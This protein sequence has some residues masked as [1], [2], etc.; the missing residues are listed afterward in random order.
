MRHD[1]RDQELVGDLGVDRPLLGRGELSER[2]V[3]DRPERDGVGDKRRFAFERDH[4]AD[5]RDEPSEPPRGPLDAIR[6]VAHLLAGQPPFRNR[7]R[8]GRPLDRRDRR[9]QL[10]GEDL[11]ELGL[12]PVELGELGAQLLGSGERTPQ[13]LHDLPRHLG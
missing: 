9:E 10:M 3:D 6:E 4:G 11:H 1:L 12:H 5:V 2:I 8:G 7:E 13:L